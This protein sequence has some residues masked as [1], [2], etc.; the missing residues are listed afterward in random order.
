MEIIS[1]RKW[2]PE[3]GIEKLKAKDWTK[4]WLAREITQIL[5]K[6]RAR[7]HTK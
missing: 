4:V 1:G 7:G 3:A 5:H 6:Q 2:E